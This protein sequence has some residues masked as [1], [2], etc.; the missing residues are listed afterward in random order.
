MQ[1]PNLTPPIIQLG[2]HFSNVFNTKVDINLRK[3]PGKMTPFWW[4]KSKMGRRIGQTQHPAGFETQTS[5][6]QGM[7]FTPAPQ[8]P[9]CLT[10]LLKVFDLKSAYPKILEWTK[11]TQDDFGW[12]SFLS[13]AI[14]LQYCT[15]NKT[16]TDTKLHI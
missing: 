16:N 1:A 9:S 2:I 10:K 6:L 15:R 3:G 7:C 12:L 5:H 13:Q 8:G 14:H 4:R 11:Q